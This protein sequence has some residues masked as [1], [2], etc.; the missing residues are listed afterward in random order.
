MNP[1]WLLKVPIVIIVVVVVIVAVVADF[2]P[3]TV[4]EF[5]HA[6]PSDI[7]ERSCWKAKI[8]QCRQMADGR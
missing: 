8:L 3:R 6:P 2:T 5:E 4:G 1:V 7:Q